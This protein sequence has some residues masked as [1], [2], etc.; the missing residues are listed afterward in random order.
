MNR[1]TFNWK[2][3]NFDYALKT[4]GSRGVISPGFKVVDYN[5]KENMV[6]LKFETYTGGGFDVLD[7][8]ENGVDVDLEKYSLVHVKLISKH[9]LCLAASLD[10]DCDGNTVSC[11]FGDPEK[12][13]YMHSSKFSIWGNTMD[14]SEGED[15]YWEFRNQQSKITFSTSNGRGTTVKGQDFQ[16]FCVINSR[17]TF[18]IKVQVSTPGVFTNSTSPVQSD[19]NENQIGSIQTKALCT[20]ELSDVEEDVLVDILLMAYK[21]NLDDIKKVASKR[22]LKDRPKFAKSVYFVNKMKENPDVLLELFQS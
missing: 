16:G 20:Q 5:G 18:L 3:E 11:D 21:H 7:V 15:H 10:F 13:V 22:I 1:V 8:K 12:N 14:L 19:L 17:A 2:I 4:F 6:K 9:E